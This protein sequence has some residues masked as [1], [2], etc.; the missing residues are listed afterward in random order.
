MAIIRSAKDKSGRWF[1]TNREAAQ[2]NALSYRARGLLWYLL[3][4]P[5]GWVW[6]EDELYKSGP[7]GRDAIRTCLGEL[8]RAGYLTSAR[9]HNPETGKFDYEKT[10]HEEPVTTDTP[11]TENPSTA[12]QTDYQ[13]AV[14]QSAV[15]QSAVFQSTYKEER[16]TNR[17]ERTERENRGGRAKAATTP[18]P[19]PPP[20]ES[21]GEISEAEQAFSEVYPKAKL[22]AESRQAIRQAVTDLD[23]WRRVLSMWRE[24]NYK[25]LIGNLLDRYRKEPTGYETHK[26]S[27]RPVVQA[28]RPAGSGPPPGLR[29][30][31]PEDW[32]A[33][34]LKLPSPNARAG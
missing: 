31:T 34:G 4:K 7:E 10:I 6:R 9:K 5:D 17:S 11:L 26:P 20:Q 2:D 23:H 15:F 18:T 22:S 25:P 30:V 28:E 24:N 27:R 32:E 14:N 3:S 12:P 8:K 21:E 33:W 13:S 29:V 16:S 1:I 19:V